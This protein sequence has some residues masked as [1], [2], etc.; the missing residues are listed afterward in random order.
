[1][2]RVRPTYDLDPVVGGEVQE[3]PVLAPP[4]GGGRVPLWRGAAKDHVLAQPGGGHH[5]QEGELVLEVCNEKALVT[6]IYPIFL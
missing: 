5:R 3:T 2:S 6:V 1:M 4:D